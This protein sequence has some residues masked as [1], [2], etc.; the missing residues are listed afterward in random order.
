VTCSGQL[1]HLGMNC[2]SFS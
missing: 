1:H 2:S